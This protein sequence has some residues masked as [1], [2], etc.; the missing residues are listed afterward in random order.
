MMKL[1][2]YFIFLMYLIGLWMFSSKRKYFLMT[3]LSLE[4]MALSVFLFLAYYLSWMMFE[5]YFLLVFMI[6]VVCEGALGLS[7]LVML[8]RSYGNDYFE[9]FSILR[10]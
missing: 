10:C 4:Y 5:M 3:L 8:V 1:M 7:I 9:S 2:M 6:F